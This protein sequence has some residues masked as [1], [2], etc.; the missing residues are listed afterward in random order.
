[1]LSGLQP[2]AIHGASFASEQTRQPSPRIFAPALAWVQR[3]L[4]GWKPVGKLTLDLPMLRLTGQVA[5]LTRISPVIIQLFRTVGITNV[6][7]ML[8][9]DGMIAGTLSRHDG[10][11]GWGSR[12]TKKGY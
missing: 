7:P 9:P 6:P 4:R 11:I 12:V 5:E 1:M 2:A 10:T 8:R 3:G